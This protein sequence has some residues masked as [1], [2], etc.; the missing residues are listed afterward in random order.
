MTYSGHGVNKGME[1]CEIGNKCGVLTKNGSHYAYNELR[2][3]QGKEV[4]AQ[5]FIDNPDIAAEIKDKILELKLP[6][7]REEDASTSKPEIRD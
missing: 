3:G 4:A 6:H 5:F 2:L 1:I 7:R